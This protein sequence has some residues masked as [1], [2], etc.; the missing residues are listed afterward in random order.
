MALKLLPEVVAEDPEAVR[1]LLRETNRCLELTHPHIVRVYDLVQDGPLAAISMEFVDGESLAKRKAAAPGGCLKLD[2]LQL[3]IGQ[4]CEALDYAHRVAKVVHRDLKPANLLLTREGQLKVTDFGI[5]RSLSDT[6]TRLIGRVSNTS[7]TLLYMSPQQL[8]GEDPAASDDIY[9]LGATLYELLT[10]K[11][12]FHTGDV[13]TQIRAVMPKP[14]NTRLASLGLDPV[15]AA[16]EQTIHA[17][18][19]KEPQDRPQSAADVA[20][21]LNVGDAGSRI[22]ETEERRPDAR[23]LEGAAPSA[24]KADDAGRVPLGSG[25]EADDE[26]TR[27][28]ERQPGPPARLGGRERER[29]DPGAPSPSDERVKNR[30]LRRWLPFVAAAVV[31]GIA[32]YL[33]WPRLEN[34]RGAASPAPALD[35]GRSKTAPLQPISESLREF[36]VTVDPPDVGAGLWLGPLSDVEIKDGKALLKD[37]PDG[38]QELTVQAPGYQPFTTRVTVKDGRGSVE[39]KLVPVRGEVSVA[40]RPGTQV[41]AVDERGRETRVG[42]VPPGGVLDVANLLT[43]GRYTLKLDHA[44]C[45]AVTVPGVEL[46]IGRTIKVAP[47]QAPLPGELRVFSVPTGAEVRVNGT[48]AGSTPATIKN[49]PSEQALRIEVF[50]HGYRRVE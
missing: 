7:G 37:L 22:Q 40:A 12:P 5:A 11:P 19:A 45:A 44:D 28:V 33:F 17:C 32:G 41:T 23:R 16:W 10:G 24:P 25:T 26:A 49:Q 15:P 48:A 9:A 47:A 20:R 50:Q 21:R 14:V 3:L 36:A 2:E 46:V 42:T 29:V 31:L 6:H 18:L 27:R 1:D 8:L 43:V 38:E 4:L 35:E 13:A 39:A 34:R 30:S